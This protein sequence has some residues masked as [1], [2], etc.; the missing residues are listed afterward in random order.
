MATAT[1]DPVDVGHRNEVT[2]VGRLSG[3]PEER[4]MPSGDVVMSF[5]LVVARPEQKLPEGVRRATVDTLE[6]SAWQAATRRSAATWADGDVI[7]VSGALRR[8]F[9]TVGGRSQSRVDVEVA[10]A[11]RLARAG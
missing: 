5:R 7:E 4:E 2:L 11:K 3:A 10:K 8:R 1:K 6:C 9:F